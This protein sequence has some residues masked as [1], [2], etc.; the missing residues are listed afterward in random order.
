LREGDK[1]RAIGV[2]G[3]AGTESPALN[4]KLLF[5]DKVYKFAI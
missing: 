4:K 3:Q 2:S 5:F 1:D